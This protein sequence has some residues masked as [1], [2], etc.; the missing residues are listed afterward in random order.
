MAHIGE[1]FAF[2]LAG[3]ARY[4]KRIPQ[5]LF[6]LAPI[7][8][9]LYRAHDTHGNAV[10]AFHYGRHSDPDRSILRSDDGDFEVIARSRLLRCPRR[11]AQSFT[12]FRQ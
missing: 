5:S 10:I 7:G 8:N 12:N 3:F 1:E 2:R 6:E 4:G 11:V 9:V